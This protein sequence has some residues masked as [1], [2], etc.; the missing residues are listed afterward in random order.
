IFVRSEAALAEF[1]QLR[2]ERCI[3]N[4]AFF[5][6]NESFGLNESFRVGTAYDSC[7][8]HVGMFNKFRFNLEWRTPNP[9]NL[10]HVIA[11][12]AVIKIPLFVAPIRVPR[13]KPAVDHRR[14]GAFGIV[15]VAAGRGLAGNIELTAFAIGNLSAVLVEDARRISGDNLTARSGLDVFWSVRNKYV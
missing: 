10:H 2:G 4:S 11:A 15:P 5:E 14:R 9:A 13:I 6:H 12:S 3:A 8:D 7:F 1:H